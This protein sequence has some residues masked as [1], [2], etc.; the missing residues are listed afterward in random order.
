MLLGA[1]SSSLVRAITLVLLA[2][3]ETPETFGVYAA[4]LGML[5]VAKALADL[6][7]TKF[8]TRAKSSP[9]VPG[10]R[11]IGVALA[12]NGFVTLAFGITALIVGALIVWSFGYNWLFLVPLGI[13]GALE[14][15][16][17]TWFAL[18]LAE[19]RTHWVGLDLIVRRVLALIVF[20][21][22]LGLMG[23]EPVF[24]LAVGELVAS[25]SSVVLAR[26][27]S[28]GQ[29]A[30][31]CLGLAKRV[32]VSA[33][34][35]WLNSLAMHS[36]NLDVLLVSTFASTVQ[37]GLFAAA[38]RL[39]GPL[40]LIP[41]ALATV[42]LPH[43]ARGKSSRRATERFVLWISIGSLGFAS[44]LAAIVPVGVP[45]VLGNEYAESVR[46]MQVIVIGLPLLVYSNLMCSWLQGVG[47]AREVGRASVFYACILLPSVAVG[48]SLYGAFGSAIGT[49]TA[50]LIFALMVLAIVRGSKH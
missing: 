43:A 49:V 2:R 10:S 46:A 32:L 31:A 37:S 15:N 9:S 25:V 13:A 50:S 22:L 41:S 6:G 36:R 38:T 18:P 21:S 24:A 29:K 28:S 12:I 33:R 19:G 3:L 30:D 23:A 16:A 42:L 20:L 14:K 34:P 40:L 47:L 1:G 27:L 44:A 17:D 45:I 48:A 39:T 8:I 26:Y 7:L 35:Y 11:D 5:V 4:V